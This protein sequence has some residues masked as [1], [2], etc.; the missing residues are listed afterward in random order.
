[1]GGPF[2]DLNS[3]TNKTKQ[4]QNNKM[5]NFSGGIMIANNNN[6]NI[7]NIEHFLV[8]YQICCI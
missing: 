4:K 6:I 2:S 5:K 1:M 3:K 8:Y 7:E